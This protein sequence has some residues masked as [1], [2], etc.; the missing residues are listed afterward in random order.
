MRRINMEVFSFRNEETGLENTG[1]H[2]ARRR[3]YGKAVKYTRHVSVSYIAI[4]TR[5]YTC[6][7]CHYRANKHDWTHGTGFQRILLQCDV[8]LLD[9]SQMKHWY[10]FVYSLMIWYMLILIVSFSNRPLLLSL[11]IRNFAAA[12]ASPWGTCARSNRNSL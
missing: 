12:T 4:S 8:H 7:W 3:E 2:K 5:L 10:L 6:L 1:E 11:Y 9:G